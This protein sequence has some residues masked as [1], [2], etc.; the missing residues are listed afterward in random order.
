MH[1][2]QR[3]PSCQVSNLGKLG[4]RRFIRR[5]PIISLIMQ[6]A[7]RSDAEASRERREVRWDT[8][9]A[10]ADEPDG[11]SL[12]EPSFLNEEQDFLSWLYSTSVAQ[13]LLEESKAR[14][15]A[16]VGANKG[17]LQ[18]DQFAEALK[19][20]MAAAGLESLEKDAVRFI[21]HEIL[22]ML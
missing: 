2:R 5:V 11:L 15:F 4:I 10:K 16:E 3:L 21:E 1:T 18:R 7:I 6:K 19:L 14:I 8:F 9:K 12:E 20:I 17:R 13:K 22:Q